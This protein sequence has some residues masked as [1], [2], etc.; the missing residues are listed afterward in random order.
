MKKSTSLSVKGL[1]LLSI[2]SI[3]LAVG[4]GCGNGW[5]MFIGS[6]LGVGALIVALRYEISKL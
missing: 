2:I 4:I 3:P 1:A 5:L 6:I